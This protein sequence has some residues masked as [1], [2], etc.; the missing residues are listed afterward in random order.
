M[1]VED[2][3]TTY[4]ILE[5]LY[6]LYWVCTIISILKTKKLRLGKLSNAHKTT[7]PWGAELRTE[8]FFSSVCRKTVH[9]PPRC[10]L[11]SRIQ[12]PSGG[13]SGKPSRMR[14]HLTWVSSDGQGVSK[15]RRR[16]EQGEFLGGGNSTGS[17]MEMGSRY[18]GLV[19]QRISGGGSD[20]L[21]F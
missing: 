10:I 6:T 16:A 8:A 17:G 3:V 11:P 18:A 21:G 2:T 15:S 7:Q 1:I 12:N 5:A 20:W 4:Y 13:E 19:P 14:R 9:L